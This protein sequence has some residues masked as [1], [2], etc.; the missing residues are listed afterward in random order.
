MKK[1]TTTSLILLIL[2]LIISTLFVVFLDNLEKNYNIR[3]D[4]S[5]NSYATTSEITN[6]II[7]NLDK[8]VNIYSLKQTSINDLQLYELIKK[9]ATISDKITYE[10]I[11]LAENP[12]FANKFAGDASNPLSADSIIVYSPDT[13][14]YRLLSPSDFLSL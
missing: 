10:H 6:K 9:Y 11:S 12:S 3:I 1:P 2:T 14:R 13:D 7:Q 4:L 8:N 5:F